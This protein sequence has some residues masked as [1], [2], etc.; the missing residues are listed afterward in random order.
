M[1]HFV[2]LV[3][4]FAVLFIST[5]SVLCILH[6]NKLNCSRKFKQ[7]AQLLLGKVDRTAYVQNPASDFQSRRESD[8]SEVT[9]PSTLC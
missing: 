9:V 1:L 2:F 5:L 4:F 6:Q 7:E 3:L 8:F